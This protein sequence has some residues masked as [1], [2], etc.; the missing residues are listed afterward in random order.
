MLG[1]AVGGDIEEFVAQL[2]EG[3][4]TAPEGAGED[5]EGHDRPRALKEGNG[6]ARLYRLCVLWHGRT[7]LVKALCSDTI[8]P[9]DDGKRLPSG[10]IPRRNC[11][12]R[13]IGT[14]EYVT[15]CS[16]GT[17]WT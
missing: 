1:G 12:D 7:C 9:S 13:P 6:L 14:S 17:S 4:G 5:R 8:L 16:R 15:D 3:E 10:H 2:H 11:G